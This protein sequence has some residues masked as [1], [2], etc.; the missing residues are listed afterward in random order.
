[1]T[2]EYNRLREIIG[3]FDSC[4]IA[5]SGGV[6]STLVTA[7]SYDVLG[8]KAVAVT[9]TSPTYPSFEL[10]E[11][12]QRA[13][14]I[15]IRHIIIESDELK[16]PGFSKNDTNRCYFCKNELFTKLKGLAV[17]LGLN[18]VL[19]GTNRDDL[20]DF[21][22]GRE[23]A[24]ELGVRSP[25]LEAGFTK[26]DIRFISRA[27]GLTNWDKPAYACLSS[28]F[29]Y[30]TEINEE[31]LEQVSKAE[32]F[33]RSLGFRIF[34]VRHHGEIARIEIGWDEF[35]LISDKNISG[36]IV[37]RL[38]GLGYHFVVLDMEGYR[39]GSLNKTGYVD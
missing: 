11:A 27:I 33:M 30:G 12:R 35:H 5:F 24:K 38:K 22:P 10:E 4:V 6:D 17:D 7:V 32:D 18:V 39:R 29:P 34:R 16:I 31:N 37:Q 2:K 26:E 9:A 36:L 25:L 21:R 15:G 14:E 3:A 1:M 19:D 20:S 23:A 28:R 13:S 8:D